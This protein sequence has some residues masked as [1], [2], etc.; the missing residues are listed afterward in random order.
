MREQT[1]LP[2]VF[3]LLPNKRQETYDIMLRELLALKPN[4][5]PRV[6]LTDF[7][8]AAI[9]SFRDHF[10]DVVQRGCFF[11]FSQCIWRKVSFN[12]YISNKGYFVL[13][14]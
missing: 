12:L 2:A 11:H 4:L 13:I 5:K 8:K 6:I 9:N 10:S 1:A 7:E 14:K 3:A